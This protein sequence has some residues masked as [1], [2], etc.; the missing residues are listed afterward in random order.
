MG[1]ASTSTHYVTAS[2][3]QRIDKGGERVW[4]LDDFRDL[5]FTA[6]AQALSRLTRSG[7]LERL[8][9]G[10]YYKTRQTA[11]GRSRP[12]PATIQKLARK[13]VFPSGIAAASMLGFTTQTGRVSEVSTSALSLPRKLMGKDTVIHARRPEAWNKLSPQDAAFLEFLR[14]GG[15]T[16]ELS[17][18]RTVQK[19]LAL[20]ADKGRFERLVNVADSEPPRVRAMLGAMGEQLGKKRSDVERLHDS[21][22]PFSK[23]DFGLLAGLEHAKRWQAKTKSST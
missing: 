9:K 21:L 22:N 11:F 5:P 20:L 10:I 15:E 14:C 12:N 16:S 19:A 13:P 4:R 17:P 7:S 18:E 8:S 2:V 1:Q 23:Y 3:R 6:V